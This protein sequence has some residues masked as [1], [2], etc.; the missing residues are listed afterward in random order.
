MRIDVY[1]D[2][3]LFDD[4]T[5]AYAEYRVFAS[6]ATSGDVVQHAIVTLAPVDPSGAHPTTGTKALCTVAIRTGS[7]RYTEV[8]APGRHP[9]E[10]IDRAA[11]RIKQ[12]LFRHD[13]MNDRR[14]P[15]QAAPECDTA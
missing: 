11:A 3:A 1:D 12:L 7:G 15:E 9:Y 4:Q 13:L 6:L 10:A 2:H 14:S 8:C 5:R